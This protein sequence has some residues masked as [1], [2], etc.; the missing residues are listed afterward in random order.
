M[1]Q[2]EFKIGFMC[3]RSAVNSLPN[4]ISLPFIITEISAFIQTNR[5][6]RLCHA[7]YIH[8]HS[9]H[10]KNTLR[11]AMK[12][13]QEG[14]V[15]VSRLCHSLHYC[16][17]NPFTA[18]RVPYGIW[19]IYGIALAYT[20]TTGYRYFFVATT[21]DRKRQRNTAACELSQ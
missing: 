7:F 4:L 10:N 18:T 13:G 6:Y 5:V 20:R 16:L 3:V 12:R 17:P 19:H 9:G 8:M 1:W 2:L 21:T 15:N 11:Y 14:F